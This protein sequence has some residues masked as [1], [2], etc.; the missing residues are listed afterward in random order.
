MN[1]RDI[2]TWRMHE[3]RLWGTPFGDPVEA[4]RWFGAM[5]AQEFG[6]AKWALGQ[7]TRASD[8]GAIE[9]LYRDGT[10]LRTHVLRP[11][12]HFVH[13]DDI[14]WV[15]QATKARVHQV[16]GTYYRKYGVDEESFAK[17]ATVFTKALNGGNELNRKE[18][19]DVLAK[20]AGL[21]ASG[22]HMAYVLMRAE[23]EAVIVSGTVGG[24]A[25]TY[26]FFDDRVPDKKS[27][28]VEE[29]IVELARRYFTSRGPA[30]VKD[31]VRWCSLTVADTKKALS[32]LNAEQDGNFYFVKPNTG[33]APKSPRIDLVQGFDEYIMSYSESKDVLRSDTPARDIDLR[34]YLHA[35]LLDG[36]VIGH[37]RLVPKPLT[38]EA[39]LYR[40]LSKAETAA[41]DSAVKRLGEFF[42]TKASWLIAGS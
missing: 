37:W 16:N 11:T 27:L 28:P 22:L 20:D 2:A 19:M 33:K 34:T 42:G 14:R 18:L 26:A 9:R 4:L 8:D 25:P 23:L 24:K 7:R 17:C 39:E 41:L 3:H 5:Q 35:I 36:Q 38:V 1:N 6:P 13:R 29:A 15:L 21:T 32:V 31:F 30:T 12:W 40:P 10:I